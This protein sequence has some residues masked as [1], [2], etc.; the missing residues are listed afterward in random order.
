MLL[1]KVYKKDVNWP[2]IFSLLPLGVFILVNIC[3]W[4]SFFKLRGG[5]NKVIALFTLNIIKPEYHVYLHN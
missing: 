1:F 5:G 3:V 2:S 4:V